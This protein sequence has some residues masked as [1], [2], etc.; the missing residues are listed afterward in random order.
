M[1]V[2]QW[3]AGTACLVLS[4]TGVFAEGK[5]LPPPASSGQPVMELTI[6]KRDGK[7]ACDPAEL[8]LP[9]DTN[10]E[11]RVV[12]RADQP[13][14][15][16]IDG[17]FEKGLVQHVDGDQGHSASEK[18]Y[19]IKLNGKATLKFRTMAAGERPYACTG[20][21]S[22]SDPFVGKYVLVPPAG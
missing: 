22:Q 16:T 4:S 6:D 3:V 2:G 8:R 9:A 1:R 12:N 20:V 10:A 17:Q 21:N 18:G 15:L 13:V 7:I 14:T 5:P 11:L 19:T